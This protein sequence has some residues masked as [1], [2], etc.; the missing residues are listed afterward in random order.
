MSLKKI[1]K[2]I[3]IGFAIVYLMVIVCLVVKLLRLDKQ[4]VKPGQ[5]W[6]RIYGPEN[7]FEKHER[8]T[9]YILDVKNGYAQYLEWGDLSHGDTLVK[10][11]RVHWIQ[12]LN[13]TLLYERK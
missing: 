9:I 6:V 4:S 13:D 8:D 1:L 11:D 3:L 7:P 12:D 5:T 2:A 10:S